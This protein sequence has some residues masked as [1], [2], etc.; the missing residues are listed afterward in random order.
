MSDI[1]TPHNPYAGIP[2]LTPTDGGKRCMLLIVGEPF[3]GKTTAAATF[4]NPLFLDFDHKV[5]PDLPPELKQSLKHTVTTP[6]PT[7]P[8]W[9]DDLCDKF[10]P[11]SNRNVPGNK[12]DAFR[13]YLQSALAKIPADVTVIIDSATALEKAFHHQTE[14][15][16]SPPISPKTGKPDGFYVWREKQNYFGSIMDLLKT[17]P[18]NVIY[19][20]H[21]TGEKNEDGAP[22]GR[23][24]PLMSGSFVD[25]I[26]SHFTLMFR[27]RIRVDKQNNYN[28]HYVWD[29]LPTPVFNS[30]NCLQ[31]KE[32]PIPATYESLRP[33]LEGSKA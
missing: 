20:M 3:S 16:E 33:Y 9:D 7:I 18:G 30:N 2:G 1:I 23:I 22:T 26:A 5:P 12:R 25:S 6:F 8:F 10:A 32:S 24:K 14:V 27:Q 28:K 4:P 13:K 17:H 29:V 15:I 19:I 31:M 11:R 21:E